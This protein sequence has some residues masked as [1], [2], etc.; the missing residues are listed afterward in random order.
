MA[1]TLHNDRRIDFRIDSE[2]NCVE[3]YPLRGALS[4][5]GLDPIKL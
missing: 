4:Q 3:A 2:D 5:R 1:G